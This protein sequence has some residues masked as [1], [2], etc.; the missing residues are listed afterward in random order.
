MKDVARRIVRALDR[1]LHLRNWLL[2]LPAS[3]FDLAGDKV[4]EWGFCLGNVPQR[5][6]LTGLDIGGAQGPIAAC[7]AAMGHAVTMLDL[8]TPP[9]EL[10]RLTFMQADF[11]THDFGSDLYD[12]VVLCSVV[13]HIGLGGRYGQAADPEGDFAAMNK[14]RHLL[15]DDGLLLLTMPVGKDMVFAPWHRIYG[16]RR[17]PKLLAGFRTENAR[18]MIKV[19][20]GPWQVASE[21]EALEINRQGL[22]YALGEFALRRA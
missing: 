10:P 22:S 9:Y 16:T 14:V 15:K 21:S 5:P 17:L 3:G 1:R 4:L 6:G 7:C 8:D 20:Y 12:L 11:M 19:P 13:E 18:F 2:G